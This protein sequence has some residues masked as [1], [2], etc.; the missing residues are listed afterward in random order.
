[1][2]SITL[3]AQR[4][5]RAGRHN[6]Q[7]VPALKKAVDQRFLPLQYYKALR[8][9]SQGQYKIIYVAPERLLTEEFQEFALRRIGVLRR[10]GTEVEVWPVK[11]GRQHSRL[12][13]H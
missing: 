11:P 3:E 13:Q 12:P 2:T 10:L 4:L 6:P 7:R 5:A 8:L 9:A 1:M